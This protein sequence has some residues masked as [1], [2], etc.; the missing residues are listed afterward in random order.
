MID[1]LFSK[2]WNADFHIILIFYRILCFIKSNNRNPDLKIFFFKK[3]PLQD[4]K[5]E[6]EPY[7]EQQTGSESG[8]EY[9]K[10]VNCHLAYLTCM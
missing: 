1:Y 9:E 6:L 3:P 2:F 10:A 4:K 8:K 7:M 5:Q